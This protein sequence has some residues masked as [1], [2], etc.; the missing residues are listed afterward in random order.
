MRVLSEALGSVCPREIH[1]RFRA[2]LGPQPADR[3]IRCETDSL[4]E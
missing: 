4:M 3:R 1:Q 2:S